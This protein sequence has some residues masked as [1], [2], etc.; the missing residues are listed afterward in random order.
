MALF[1]R[2]PSVPT[3]GSTL[4]GVALLA[5]AVPAQAADA[6]IEAP[7]DTI[8]VTAAGSGTRLGHPVPKALVN[9]AGRPILTHALDGVA[10]SGVA[11][12][13]VVTVTLGT[14]AD[15]RMPCSRSNS[16]MSSSV[17]RPAIT[18]P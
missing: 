7:A 2:R 16:T 17:G 15:S 9:L 13:V 8:V 4:A 12:I 14:E 5:L 18:G 3:I 1:A 10:R 11:G 6:D